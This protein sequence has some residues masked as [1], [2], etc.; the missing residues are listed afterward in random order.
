MNTSTKIKWLLKSSGI[1]TYRISKE[2][3]ESTQFLDRYKKEP[4]LIGGMRLEKAEILL[5]Y[6][7]NL[8]FEDVFPEK[9]NNQQILI[10]DAT[11]DEIQ[12]WFESY[13]YSVKLN[14]IK[15][16]KDMFVVNFDTVSSKKFNKY[17]YGIRNLYFLE[18]LNI[19]RMEKFADFI[20]ACGKCIE[21]G[22]S[23]RLY[24][25]NG[26]TYQIVFTINK[27]SALRALN[28]FKIIETDVYLD[29][30]VPKLSDEDGLLG[31]DDL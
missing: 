23:K 5:K 16:H 31:A 12:K 14:W 6:I 27:P 24:E 9:W 4:G 15:E 28:L 13:P 19:E 2:T 29:D 10:E 7:S 30:A 3:G 22:G 1:S 11:E 20:R 18:N 17:P 8:S 25:V 26:K 21:L